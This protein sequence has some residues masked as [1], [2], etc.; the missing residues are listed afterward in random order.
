MICTWKYLSRI[1]MGRFFLRQDQNKPIK[2]FLLTLHCA[3]AFGVVITLY[4]MLGLCFKS[5]QAGES[6]ICYY[7]NCS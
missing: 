1:K 6:L 5:V 4:Y 7:L 2:N 3:A